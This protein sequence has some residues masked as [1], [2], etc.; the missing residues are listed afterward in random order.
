MSAHRFLR[1]AAAV[2]AAALAVGCTETAGE[3]DY[4]SARLEGEVTL[5]GRPID[6]GSIQFVP[7]D[8]NAP[9]ISTA[10]L[11]GRYVAPKVGKGKVTAI[12][13]V[14]P[15]PR[16]EVVSS[17]YQPKPTVHIP[18]RYKAGIPIEVADDKDDQDFALSSK[19]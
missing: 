1:V 6:G 14:E 5:D 11:G 9:P 17:D 8:S 10:I 19:K 2:A 7:K 4:P 18:D 3:A 15:P 12:I 16:P 13:G